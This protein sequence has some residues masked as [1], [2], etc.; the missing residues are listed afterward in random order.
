MKRFA[1]FTL[2]LVCSFSWVKAQ[3]GEVIYDEVITST[4]STRSSEF[5]L[6][7]DAKASQYF[8]TKTQS[9]RTSSENVEER[10]KDV[11]PFVSKS[12][13]D[14]KIIYN[15]ASLNKIFTIT[16]VMPLQKWKM[17]TET[18]KIGNYLCK[19]ATT[20]FRGRTYTAWYTESLP[21]IGGPWKFDGLP[22][23]ILEVASNDG[24]LSIKA[25]TTTL[26][27][28]ALPAATFDI[29]P[30]GAITWDEYC[31]QTM[32]LVKR[33]EKLVAAKGDPGDEYKLSFEMIE[34]I[35]VKEAT[36]TK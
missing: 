21:F 11:I 33:W 18:K 27:V 28:G 5:C 10:N 30:T 15:Q 24:F 8:R 7:I 31:K 23:M 36:V 32:A 14:K 13:S 12:F 16:E 2:A 1:L 35:G 20:Q 3:Y 22:G 9:Q 17:L 26:K 19:K 34:E 4:H 29:N 6:R 25:R